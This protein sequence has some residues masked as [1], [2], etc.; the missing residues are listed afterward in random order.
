[1][2]AAEAKFREAVAW[3]S[4]YVLV[5]E[6]DIFVF[7]QKAAAFKLNCSCCV[8]S[9]GRGSLG[10]S[11]EGDSWGRTQAATV[12]QTPLPELSPYPEGHEKPTEDTQS[13]P[14]FEV[15]VKLHRRAIYTTNNPSG[16]CLLVAAAELGSIK[17]S[18]G[19]VAS[20]GLEPIA[21][22]SQCAWSLSLLKDW[23]LHDVP[24]ICHRRV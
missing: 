4:I 9:L 13:I 12:S 14:S 21:I 1:M 15:A 6:V 19:V 16:S 18:T 3:H 17:P 22:A 23:L 24:G 20:S 8:P 2:D 5:S 10:C 7:F 11:T